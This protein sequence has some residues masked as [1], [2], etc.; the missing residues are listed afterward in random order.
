MYIVRTA[1]ILHF[2]IQISNLK[3]LI[4]SRHTVSLKN[5]ILCNKLS[6]CV[7]TSNFYKLKKKTRHLHIS[8]E[9]S[10]RLMSAY[11]YWKVQRCYR[12]EREECRV[13][14]N[15]GK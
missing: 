1:N 9:Q 11:Y 4:I 7:C 14:V 6:I 5:S 3:P 15:T 13:Q 10:E 2:E 8:K 12:P